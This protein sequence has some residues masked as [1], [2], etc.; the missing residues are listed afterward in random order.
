MSH[1]IV[2]RAVPLRPNTVP[3]T[4]RILPLTVVYAPYYMTRDKLFM[5]TDGVNEDL[6]S[7]SKN[8]ALGYFL[9]NF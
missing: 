8:K 4:Y 3:F 6:L 7:I 9:N 2:L 1:T 5:I